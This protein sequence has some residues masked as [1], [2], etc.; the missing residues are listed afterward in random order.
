MKLIVTLIKVYHLGYFLVYLFLYY[1]LH[2]VY[3]C[4]SVRCGYFDCLLGCSQGLVGGAVVTAVLSSSNQQ[5]VRYGVGLRRGVP[6]CSLVHRADHELLL[7]L[8]CHFFLGG[9][10]LHVV[11]VG[12]DQG[13]LVPL[14]YNH[15]I[16]FYPI[17]L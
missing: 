4:L 9:L 3:L 2:C 15:M 7:D 6:G 16:L 12:E 1:F 8:A 11:L 13:D 5:L 10:Y 17:Y 14:K